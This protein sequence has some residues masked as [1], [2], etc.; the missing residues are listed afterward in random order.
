[1]KEKETD[2]VN[3]RKEAELKLRELS[4]D[5]NSKGKQETMIKKEIAKLREQHENLKTQQVTKTTQISKLE[6]Q[7]E[8]AKKNL[9]QIL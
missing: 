8:T 1:M 7:I 4:Q 2:L 3:D 9:E 6:I 5:G